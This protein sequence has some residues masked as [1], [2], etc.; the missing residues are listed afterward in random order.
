MIQEIIDLLAEC[1]ER[2]PSEIRGMDEFRTYEEW[3]SLAYLTVI[4]AIDD[5]YG[6]VFPLEDFRAC[7][8]VCALTAYVESHKE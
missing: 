3:D 2:E 6:F 4:A 7:R 1:L 8:T 5:N